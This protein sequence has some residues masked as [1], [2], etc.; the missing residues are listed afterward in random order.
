MV[1]LYTTFF[2]SNKSPRNINNLR[3]SS[4]KKAQFC[5]Q[6]KVNNTLNLSVTRQQCLPPL[7]CPLWGGTTLAE[8]IRYVVFDG[9]P[10]ACWPCRVQGMVYN[11]LQKQV[12]VKYTSK[13]MIWRLSKCGG[14][15]SEKITI[16]YISL[17]NVTKSLI[18]WQGSLMNVQNSYLHH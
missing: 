6:I 4:Q 2:S 14:M 1:S 16:E 8:K 17:L 11:Q 10:Y 7:F 9:L 18:S 15:K 3:I 5:G 13:K 12:C